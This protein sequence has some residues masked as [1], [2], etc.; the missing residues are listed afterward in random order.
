MKKFTLLFTAYLALTLTT[1]SAPTQHE[2]G[3]AST[4]SKKHKA[5]IAPRIE[6]VNGKKYYYWP[7]LGKWPNG[8]LHLQGDRST[9]PDAQWFPDAGLGLFMHWGIVSEFE[10]TGEAWSG[11]WSAQKEKRGLFYPQT[12]IWAAAETFDPQDYNAE[13]WMA[14]AKAAGF[15]Y[16]V[17]TT[18]HHDGYALWD[19]DFAKIGVRQYLNGRDLV[20]PYVDACRNN[21]VKVGFY[22]SGMDWYYDRLSMNFSTQLGT[23]VNYKGEKVDSFPTRPADYREKFDAFNE[24]QVRELLEFKPDLWWSDGGAGMP[25]AKIRQ[26]QPGILFNNRNLDRFGDYVT[27]EGYHMGSPRYM[28]PVVENGWWWESCEI[29]NGGSWHYR[30]KAERVLNTNAFLYRLAEIRSMGGNM[31]ANIAPRPDGDM[32][33][34]AYRLFAEMGEWMKTGRE[35]I[36]KINGGC[37]LNPDKANAPITIGDEVWYV[38]ARA[39][40]AT[41]K[42]PI[43]LKDMVRPLS[44][45]LLKTGEE[46]AY[47]FAEGVLR[48]TIPDDLK[49]RGKGPDV[50][51][52]VFDD[53]SVSELYFFKNR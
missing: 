50:I 7:E 15:D 39:N 46:L 12:E 33:D 28:R 47:E 25:L 36:F 51:K 3:G 43:V 26:L 17:L 8:K 10:P 14:A 31:L 29:V 40:M 45:S 35:S 41:Q 1:Y 18:K 4:Y 5:E 53:V 22:Y 2:D 30:Q 27:P 44:V 34:Q 52:L 49:L 16:A 48:L 6:E 32:P 11:R 38:H 13:K 19:S 23:K 9:H 20:K 21:G 24:G 37:G 42:N